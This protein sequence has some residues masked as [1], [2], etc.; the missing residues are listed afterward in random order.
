GVAQQVRFV[1]IPGGHAYDWN[2][3]NLL[4]LEPSANYHAFYVDPS[5]GRKLD[6][7]VLVRPQSDGPR[8]FD[9]FN[10]H[11]SGATWSDNGS[12]TS[13]GQV[14][15]RGG[16]N[17]LTTLSNVSWAD[18]RVSVGAG[19]SAEAG[20]VFRYRDPANYVVAVYNP[21]QQAIYF[22]DRKNGEWGPQFG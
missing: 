3:P 4:G 14:V 11:A 6:L 13:R 2:S 15:L 1:F 22:H 18:A 17:I 20:I 10:G 8:I 9:N 21:A 16:T 7:G 12:Q 5:S 19:S